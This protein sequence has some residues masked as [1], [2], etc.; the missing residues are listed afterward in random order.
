V[1]IVNVLELV[2]TPTAIAMTVSGGLA[3]KYIIRGEL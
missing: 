1:F 3:V 2:G